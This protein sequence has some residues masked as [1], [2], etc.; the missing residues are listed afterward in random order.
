MG[1]VNPGLSPSSPVF[2]SRMNVEP[3][4]DV[5]VFF[6]LIVCLCCLNLIMCFH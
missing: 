5:F 6:N 4:H 1:P 2:A 3:N